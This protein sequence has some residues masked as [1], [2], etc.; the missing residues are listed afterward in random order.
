MDASNP[1]GALLTIDLA[2]LVA[3]WRLLAARAQPAECAAV[4]K[5]DA[6]GLGIGT[7]VPALARAGCRTFFVAHL[8]EA[9]RARRAAPE[10]AVYVLN[11][12][13]PGA[14]A[15]YAAEALRPVLGT[16][17]ELERWRA[18]GGGPSALHVDTGM[19]RLGLSQDEA[20]AGFRADPARYEWIRNRTPMKR[21]GTAQDLA[22]T[23][24][25][26]SGD[27]SA[28]MTGQVLIVDGGMTIAI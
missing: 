3:N 11:G 24:V 17:E 19:N 28:F 16:I 14:E 23:A 21:W 5:A 9:R 18:A 27:A 4:V 10:A 12:L 8:E 2:A 25:F 7:V 26:L 20:L 1:H 22:G 15:D 13:P 6:Y